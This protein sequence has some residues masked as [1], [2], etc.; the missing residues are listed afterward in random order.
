MLVVFK[1]IALF[2]STIHSSMRSSSPK[3]ISHIH[4]GWVIGLGFGFRMI[5]WKANEETVTATERNTYENLH[6]VRLHLLRAAPGVQTPPLRLPDSLP[7]LRAPHR[8]PPSDDQ[9]PCAGARGVGHLGAN[10]PSR[11]TH[12]LSVSNGAQC[13]LGLARPT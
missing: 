3:P 4:N 1:F 6:E 9:S 11:N 7:G 8:H 2:D 12:P 10:A 5:E 13:G